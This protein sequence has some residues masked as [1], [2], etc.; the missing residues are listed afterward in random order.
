[1]AALSFCF[2]ETFDACLSRKL[3]CAV[4]NGAAPAT[5]TSD[6]GAQAQVVGDHRKSCVYVWNLIFVSADSEVY[7][8]FEP[9]CLLRSAHRFFINWDSF[10]RPAALSLFPCPARRAFAVAARLVERLG[11]VVPFDPLRIL[12]AEVSL[13]IS[14]SS[15]RTIFAVS[16]RF[17]ASGRSSNP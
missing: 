15:S 11:C 5:V 9:A 16:T 17:I 1:M 10:L 8:A 4:W 2:A 12:R 3:R 7:F 13:A 14:A 6:S